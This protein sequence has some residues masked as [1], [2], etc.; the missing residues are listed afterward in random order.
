MMKSWHVTVMQGC[1]QVYQRKCISAQQ[2]TDF[3]KEVKE[4]YKNVDA[5]GKPLKDHVP[6]QWHREQF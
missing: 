5:E 2:A 4:K 1:K 3:L 6:Y